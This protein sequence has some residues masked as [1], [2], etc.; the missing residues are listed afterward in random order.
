MLQAAETAAEPPAWIHRIETPELFHLGDSW[1]GG[2]VELRL[3]GE[4]YRNDA[5]SADPAADRDFTWF[6]ALPRLCWS[7]PRLRAL[8]EL[9]YGEEWGDEAGTSAIDA[10]RGDVLQAFVDWRASSAASRLGRIEVRAGR[11]L[12]SFGSER[13]IAPR[14]GP[15]VMRAFDGL[16]ATGAWSDWQLDVV[17]AR[18][19]EARVGSFDDAAATEESLWLLHAS[20]APALERPSGLDLYLI[21][22]ENDAAQYA[23]GIGHEQR[24][25]LGCRIFGSARDWDW[26][27]EGF[28]QAGRFA[29]Q[30]IRAWSIASDTGRAFELGGRRARLGAKLDVIS[31]DRDATD[32]T[33]ETFNPLFP[34]GKYFGE[35][36]LLGPYNLVDVHPSLALQLDEHRSLAFGVVGYWRQSTGDG[37]YDNGGHLLRASGGSDARFV[38][39]Q[40]DASFEWELGRSLRLSISGSYFA[41]G[42]FLEETGA[43]RD[44]AFLSLELTFG[45]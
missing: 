7:S 25:T 37:V 16:R 19:V 27:V 9:V 10:D 41:T 6:R 40:L 31:G 23:S 39:T 24:T 42:T 2:D 28:A 13:L 34:N 43:S 11:Q 4:S 22:F 15:N 30:D 17:G 20:R 26:N 29:G 18:P 45:R 38:G 3:R 44:V 33:L 21:G 5:W 12:L 36:G 32:A 14:Y 8:L 1:I 35:I